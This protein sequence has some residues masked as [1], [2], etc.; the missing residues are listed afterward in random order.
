LKEIP[1]E[2]GKIQEDAGR[3]LLLKGEGRLTT[4]GVGRGFFERNEKKKIA[5]SNNAA[6]HSGEGKKWNRFVRGSGI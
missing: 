5:W 1:M 4:Q 6:D 3:T 2:D